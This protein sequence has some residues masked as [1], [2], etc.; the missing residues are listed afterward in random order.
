MT[1]RHAIP[2]L[3]VALCAAFL[4]LAPAS[5]QVTTK[6]IASGLSR[7]LWAGAPAGDERVFVATKGGG[8]RIVQNGQLLVTPYLNLSGKISL[9]GEQGLLGVAF[10]P[11]YA[12]NGFVFVNY[13]DLAGN[14]VISRFT[15]TTD[16]NLADLA[17]E[18]VVLTATQPFANHNGGDLHFGPLDGYLYIF[19]GDGGDANDPACRAQKLNSS[20]GKCLRIDVDSATPYAIPPSN[21]FVGQVGVREEVFHYGLRNPWRNGFDRLTGDLYIGDVGQDLREE[22]DVAPAGS[23]GLNFGWKVMEG[24]RCNSTVSCLAGTPP[25]NDPTLVLPITELLHS[26]GSFAITGGYVYRG[27]ACPSEYGKYFYADFIDNK[28]RSLQYD[29]PSGTVSNLSDRTAE[30]AP[31]GGLAIRNIASFGEDGFGE[32]LII[33]ESSSA[34]GEVFK[35]VPVGAAPASAAVRNGAGG[36]RACLSSFSLPILGNVWEARVDAAGHPGAALTMLV[37]YAGPNSGVFLGANEIL[38]DTSS[39]RLFRVLAS[40]TGG[41]DAFRFGVPCDVALAGLTTYVQAVIT[42][43]SLELCNALDVSTGYF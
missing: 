8:I 22:I 1:F 19:L 16:P 36:N 38:V 5:A 14:T 35:M 32:L 33:D 28:I 6:L 30:L 2:P 29:V 41:T 3:R 21:P 37:G 31:G 27:C 12:S 40:S 26:D 4:L 13:T 24:T 43:G 20:L 39:A 17:S 10:H 7:P 34:M 42:G 15:V 11:N 23:A 18:L 9:G 25:C